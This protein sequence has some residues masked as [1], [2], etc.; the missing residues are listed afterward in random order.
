MV[1]DD[2]WPRAAIE[3][4]RVTVLAGMWLGAL[5]GGVG[6]RLAML[7]LR[8]TSPSNVDGRLSDDGF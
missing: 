3:R 2:S 5:I 8:F 4:S 1:D 7:A 6:G